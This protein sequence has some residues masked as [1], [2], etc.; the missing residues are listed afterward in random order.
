M[1]H[2]SILNT[3]VICLIKKYFRHG[4]LGQK[5]SH[6]SRSTLVLTVHTLLGTNALVILR[7]IQKHIEGMRKELKMNK[8]K[9]R[10]LNWSFKTINPSTV[11]QNLHYYTYTKAWCTF[12]NIYRAWKQEWGPCIVIP[13]HQD[14]Y[15]FEQTGQ[16][17]LVMKG[18]WSH[19][20]LS[21]WDFP[22]GK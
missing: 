4:V 7:V 22:G 13:L 17:Q 1:H 15:F 21:H 16:R 8:I 3:W 12:I 18:T 9:G 11:G 20:V 2:L 19:G 14:S 5:S 10:G 6:H